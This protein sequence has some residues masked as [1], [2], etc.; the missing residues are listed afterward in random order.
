MVHSLTLANDVNCCHTSTNSLRCCLLSDLNFSNSDKTF[1][2]K[3]ETERGGSK[4]K[5]EGKG[6]RRD[7][8]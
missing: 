2:Y 6:M 1:S 5:K 8:G 7:S 3:R 4:I